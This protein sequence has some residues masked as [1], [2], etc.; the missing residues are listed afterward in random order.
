MIHGLYAAANG[1]MAI[2]ERQAAIANNIANASTAGFRRHEPVFIGFRQLFMETG[3]G[4]RALDAERAPGGGVKLS[5]TFTDYRAGLLTKTG[6]PL[7]LALVGPGFLTVAT[8]S[9]DRFTRN[10]RLSISESG[11]LVTSEGLTVQSIDGLPIDV[12]GG[13]IEVDGEGN[14]RVSGEFRGQLRIVEF[15]QPNLLEREGASTFRANDEV[16]A[17]SRAAGATSIL[18][19]SLEGSNVELPRE[20]TGMLL[21]A[22]A[23]AANQRVI[24]ATDETLNRAID[25]IGA[26]S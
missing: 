18:S 22:R 11:S 14:V 12:Q 13:P 25:R 16:L 5:Q 23:Y 8:E 24:T 26:P 7:D 3:V 9:G 2:E 20:I 17:T 10:G 15:D 19:E 1:M 21:A 6:N 4:P